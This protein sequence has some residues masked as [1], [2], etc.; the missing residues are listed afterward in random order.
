[1]LFRSRDGLYATLAGYQFQTFLDWRQQHDPQGRW[2]ALHARLGGRPVPSLRRALRAMELGR[3]LEAL[4]AVNGAPAWDRLQSGDFAELA[5][6]WAELLGAAGATA[7]AADR[8]RPTRAALAAELA[9]VGAAMAGEPADAADVADVADVADAAGSSDQGAAEPEA[10]ALYV[11]WQQRHLAAALGQ[12]VPPEPGLAAAN[13]A[14]GLYRL[15]SDDLALCQE[16]MRAGLR[17][18]LP[19]DGNVEPVLAAADLLTRHGDL[20]G[21]RPRQ[22]LQRLFADRAAQEFLQA[23]CFA[24]TW[25]FSKESAEMLFDCAAIALPVLDGMPGAAA[26]AAAARLKNLA[27]AAGYRQQELLARLAGPA[28]GSARGPA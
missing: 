14:E 2:Q 28:A 10:A 8:P 15:G 7:P 23:N 16:Q 27:A 1:M 20:L 18:V 22:A 9:A 19:A 24:E 12:P 5:A 4:A 13:P 25:Y 3:V 17:A 26:R 21:P 11:A 6:A